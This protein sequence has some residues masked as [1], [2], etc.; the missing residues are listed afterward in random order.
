[1][2]LGVRDRRRRGRSDGPRLGR[3]L[4]PHPEAVRGEKNG[5]EVVC[6]AC[7]AAG[8]EAS[9][10]LQFTEEPLDET[11]LSA[12]LRVD[13]SLPAPIGQRIAERDF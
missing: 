9:E 7:L 2:A 10:V 4:E 6:G 12:E 8:G 3:G 5:C 1:M 11:A 13:G